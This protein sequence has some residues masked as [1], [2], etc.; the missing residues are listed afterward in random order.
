MIK[1][2][3]KP[4]NI[5]HFP[6][7]TLLMKEEVAANHP[8]EITWHYENNEEL[9]A[10]YFL[11][12]HIRSKGVADVT[13]KMPYIPNA[14]QDRVKHGEDIFTLK[15]FSQMI[16]DL[17]FSSVTVLDPH[18]YVSEALI[19]RI[20]IQSPK[21]YVDK[22]M[23]RIGNK[24]LLFYPDEGAMKR[25]SSMF[26]QPYVFG[27]KKR[28]WSTG[29][30]QGLSIS[31]RTEL[32]ENSTILI[33]DDICSRGGTFYHSAKALKELGAK[34]I[35]LYISHC[36]NTVLEG[37]LIQSDLIKRIYTTN[38]IFTKTNEKVEVFDYE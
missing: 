36:E 1:Y 21:K 34:E 4:I 26:H 13:L 29:E 16:N 3:N 37:D 32:V 8:V 5:N 14:R 11:T 7:G 25:Y 33:V 9:I 38:S 18:S 12:K 2:N 23:E 28:D 10:L 22:T 20:S 31:G 24:V 15:Y 27:I 17:G 35:Y 6:D 19:D 30:I